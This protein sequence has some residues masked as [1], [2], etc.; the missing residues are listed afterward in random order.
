MEGVWRLVLGKN[1]QQQLPLAERNILRMDDALD[2]LYSRESGEDVR[3]P[4][5]GH[6]ASQPTVARWLSETAR[7]TRQGLYRLTRPLK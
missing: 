3:D 4:Q 6:G 5:G 2:F 7:M 1:A